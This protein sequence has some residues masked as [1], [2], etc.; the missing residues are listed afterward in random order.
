[1]SKPLDLP[2][3][4]SST[5]LGTAAWQEPECYEARHY[6]MGDFLLGWADGQPL[7]VHDDRHISVVSNTRGGKGVSTIVLNLLLWLGPCVVIDPKGENA[8]VTARRRASGSR[9]SHGLGQRVRILVPFGS[10]RTAED[11]FADLKGCFNPLD[12]L[13]PQSEESVD[14]AGRIADALIVGENSSDPFWEESARTVLKALILH[15]R[16][17]ADFMEGERNLASV[18]A[19]AMGGYQ[20]KSEL[21][22]Q[23]SGAKKS[24]ASPHRLLYMAM[25][26]NKRFGGVIANAGAMLLDMEENSPR[27]LASV[28]Q[29][30]R[31]NT[32]FLDSPAMKAVLSRSDF[33]LGELKTN[34]KGMS[35]YIC[36][37]QRFIETHYRWLR[38]MT[39]LTI[40]EMEK[41]PGQPACGHRVL[42]VLDEFPALRRMRV[43]ENAAAQIAG[44]GVKLMFVVQTLAQLRDLYKDNWETLLANAGAKLFF[45][46]DD[47]FTREYVSKLVGEHEVT[48]LVRS[49][50]GS[51]NR[52]RNESTSSTASAS[53][54][55]TVGQSHSGW[56]KFA[57]RTS[58]SA[59]AGQSASVSSSVS[60]SSG[61]G[62]S[63]TVGYS[64]TI[65]RRALV[66]PDEVGRRF[67]SRE[68]PSALVLLSGEQPLV[69]ERRYYFRQGWA[70]G[71][72]DP[73]PDHPRPPNLIALKTK[74]N[75]E[76]EAARTR[77]AER[78]EQ[79]RAARIK[80]DSLAYALRVRDAM[81]AAY[82]REQRLARE[83]LERAWT[84]RL[85]RWW[86]QFTS[87]DFH[88][89]ARWAAIAA[90]FGCGLYL[91]VWG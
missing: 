66:T 44:F 33:A 19:L 53:F 89:V 75:A 39:A 76:A 26:K 61:S 30:L 43:I 7:G 11:D 54:S 18:R 78:E 41:V 79:A 45:C 80:A 57:P 87:K 16:T 27:T 82:Q 37:P 64:E 2:A 83:A 49:V 91:S 47:H 9:Y 20:D 56:G 10:V 55:H 24:Q 63:L 69:L 31:T 42:A 5:P 3:Q 74:R 58:T 59:S 73:H 84:F 77:A 25:A 23:L 21:V 70:Q 8:M 71:F 36:L 38:M 12:A 4:R 51:E 68:H 17:S 22:R 50:S 14:D 13:D 52:S 29:T 86:L 60:T 34:P 72:F 6:K 15:V 62:E 28:L 65:Q 40:T 81:D 88:G 85:K 67:G 46:N 90:F 1:M 35:L 48:K 32:E